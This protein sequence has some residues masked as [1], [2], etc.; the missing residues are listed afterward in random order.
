MIRKIIAAA[1]ITPGEAVLEIGPGTGVLTEALVEAGA[2]VTAV[3]ADPDLISPLR[4]RFGDA[5]QLVQGDI[6]ALPAAKYPASAFKLIANIPYN[7][8]SAIFQ[9]FLSKEPRPTRLVLMVQRE[10]A[11]RVAARPPDMSL[12]SVVCQLYGNVKKAT[13]VPKGA[14]RPI[15]KVDSAVIVLD[16]KGI[17]AEIE[18]IVSIAKAGFSSPR[19][20]LHHNLASIGIASEM[21]KATLEEIG[22]DPRA[23]AEVLTAE[24]WRT[25]YSKLAKSART[26]SVA[27]SDR[28][29]HK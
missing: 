24:D 27:P 26:R 16:V 29:T 21:T 20:Q 8:T 1:D 3:E 12:L 19:K 6:L 13:N 10:V 7:I 2:K 5:I 28:V 9:R 14:F 4:A 23:R 17:P 11:D 15:P 25:L 18:P 22:K